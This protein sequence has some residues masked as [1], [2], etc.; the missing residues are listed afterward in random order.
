MTSELNTHPLPNSAKNSLRLLTWLTLL[1]LLI[2]LSPRPEWLQNE[3]LMPLW[4]HITMET[5]AVVVAG[6]IFGIAWNSKSP[7]RPAAILILG[8]GFLSIGLLDYAHLLSFRGMPDF[9]TPAGAEKGLNFWLSA[10]ITTALILLAVALRKDQPFSFAS[11][12][13]FLLGGMLIFTATIYIFGLFYA[14]LWPHTFIA[15]QGLTHFKIA[16]EYV[17]SFSLLIPAVVFYRKTVKEPDNAYA[18]HLFTATSITILSELCFTVY[19][20]VAD[21]FNLLGHLYKVLAYIYIYRAVFVTSVEEPFNKLSIARAASQRTEKML[22]SIINHVPA[23]VFW[24]DMSGRYLGANNLFLQ[25]AGVK[26]FQQIEGKDDRS[27][28]PEFA[29]LY[30]EDDQRILA[31]GQPKMNYEE[32]IST[33]DGQTGWLLTSKAPLYDTDGKH[34]IGILGTYSDITELRKSRDII[35]YQANYDELTSLP[36]RRQ[37]R[38]LLEEA[39]H[40]ASEHNYPVAV[41][42]I[43]IDNFKEV[44][45][46]LGHQA[47]DLLLQ[48]AG[49]RINQR[50]LQTGQIARLGGDEFVILLSHV[51]NKE[52]IEKTA[53]AILQALN[54]KFELGNDIAYVS[55]SI[56]ISL[57]PY[58]TSDPAHLLKNADQALY[59]AKYSGKNQ[60]AY[61]TPELEQNAMARMLIGNDLRVALEG[62]QLD[63]YYQPIVD[64][65]SGNLHKAEALIRWRHPLKGMISPAEFIPIAENTGSILEIGDWVF[66]QA[67]QQALHWRKEFHRDIQVSLNIS[68]LQLQADKT[69]SARFIEFLQQQGLPEHSIVAEITEGLLTNSSASP[70]LMQFRDAGVQVAIDDFGTGFSSLSYLK[71]FDIDYIKIDQSFT[72]NLTPGSDDHALCEAIIVMAHKLGIKVIAEGIETEEQKKLLE[73]M[74]CDFGQ[75]YLFSAPVPAKQFEQEWIKR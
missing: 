7:E 27:V 15:G 33:A 25:D 12:P 21:V 56:G 61:F 59:Q 10:R 67:V 55:A 14:D 32:P 60:F 28:F 9:F 63:L 51:N 37:F 74:E 73:M 48:E 22:Q 31:T 72:R 43:D 66:R 65:N 49:K 1:F 34:V 30:M 35:N 41:L 71:R 46:T 2:W 45:D 26:T 57:F 20:N 64:L 70:Q 40:N 42:Q 5:F 50:L 6:L 13:R 58:D 52:E 11:F 19:S 38:R 75:G 47:G 3:N 29:N 17:I 68:P 53:Q 44:N 54:E 62:E 16:T 4:L 23:R 8:C 24:K 69:T 18:G 36:N 39:V